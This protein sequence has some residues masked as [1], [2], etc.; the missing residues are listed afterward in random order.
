MRDFP[1]RQPLLE[2][3]G[4]GFPL[5]YL[6]CKRLLSYVAAIEAL[7]HLLAFL[8]IYFYFYD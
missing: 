6:W 8:G 3:K 4:R 7:P 2:S 1:N 5:N